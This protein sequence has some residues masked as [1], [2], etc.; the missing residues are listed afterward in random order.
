[1]AAFWPSV[2]L[3]FYGSIASIDPVNTAY[4]PYVRPITLDAHSACITWSSREHLDD[5][6]VLDPRYPSS[7][8]LMTIA[9]ERHGS[10]LVRRCKPIEPPPGPPGQRV[11]FAEVEGSPV[12]VIV[13]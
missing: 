1:V 4:Q 13:N 8:H 5:M 7:R 10:E 11:Y 12:D 2:M 3:L 6:L 9:S